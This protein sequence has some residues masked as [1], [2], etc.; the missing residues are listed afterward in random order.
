[1]GPMNLSVQKGILPYLYFCAGL[2]FILDCYAAH[3]VL[4]FRCTAKLK[5]VVVPSSSSSNIFIKI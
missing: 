4:F 5:A 2:T 3:N 1:M